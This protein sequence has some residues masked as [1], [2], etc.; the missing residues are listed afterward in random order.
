LIFLQKV[1]SAR[2]SCTPVYTRRRVESLAA[3][4]PNS[5]FRS[6]SRAILRLGWAPRRCVSLLPC[7]RRDAR[8]VAAFPSGTA[9]ALFHRLRLGMGVGDGSRD[10][11]IRKLR[12]VLRT[13]E[14]ALAAAEERRRPEVED[15]ERRALLERLNESTRYWASVRS[16]SVPSLTTRRLLRS[17]ARSHQG[18]ESRRPRGDGRE[19]PLRKGR[20]REGVPRGTRH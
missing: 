19:A 11:L 20:R 2:F 8:R 14:A 13:A 1:V 3:R 7:N 18:G 5:P 16:G 4:G 6:E 15:V 12:G 17:A 9:E 10:V